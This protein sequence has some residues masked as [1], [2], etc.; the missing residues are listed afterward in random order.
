MLTCRRDRAGSWRRELEAVLLVEGKRGGE[1]EGGFEVNHFVVR[2][3]RE[4]GLSSPIQVNSQFFESLEGMGR[5][6]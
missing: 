4:K 1:G 5:S 2:A 3:L 6:R